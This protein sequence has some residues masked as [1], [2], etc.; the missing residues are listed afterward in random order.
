MAAPPLKENIMKASVIVLSWNGMNDL[1]GCLDAV[2]SQGF[3]LELIVVDNASTDGSPDFVAS[4]YPDA[5]LIRNERNLGFAAGSNRG[6]RAATGDVL[7]LLNQDTVVRA[8]WL[9]ALA[10]A[11][12]SDPGRGIVGG[13]ALYPDGR[14]QHA[15]GFVDAQGNGDH[16]GYRQND[17]GQFEQ[18]R[19]V[20][21]VT[22]AA[23]AISRAA[24]VAVGELDEDFGTAYWEDAD[25]CYRVREAGF[26]IVYVPQAVLMHKEASMAAKESHEA[27]YGLQRNRLRFVLKHWPT[28][29][30][31]DEFLPAERAWLE[32]LGEGGEWLVA[33]THHAYLHHL[34]HLDELVQ[35]RAPALGTAPDDTDTLAQVLLTLRAIVPLKPAA[36]VSGQGAGSESVHKAWTDALADLQQRS[37]LREQPARSKIPVLGW[38]LTA[39]RGPWNRAVTAA[40]VLPMLHQQVEFNTR[41]V[42]VLN[43]LVNGMEGVLSQY[44]GE[45]GRELGELADEIRRL[46]TLVE[47]A[48]PTDKDGTPGRAGTS[49]N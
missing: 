14:I 17:A 23:L 32:G 25:W 8:G 41:V 6:L 15:G 18:V 48:N 19:E 47:R 10:E 11:L 49:G 16:Y 12:A 43:Q 36:M 35:L 45:N 27:M 13:K 37:S 4:H 31:V 26:R 29:R 1:Q 30:L 44:L 9:Q 39:L 38:L 22:G 33:A 7:V 20:D 5:H 46:Q 28:K 21:F 42:A 40:Y 2:A 34:L 24:F 3:D